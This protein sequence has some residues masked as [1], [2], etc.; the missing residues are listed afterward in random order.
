MS[1]QSVHKAVIMARGLGTRLRAQAAAELSAEQQAV[2]ATGVK[3]MMPVGGGRP[4]V[5]HVIHELAEAGIDEVCLVIGPEHE[6]V[7]ERYANLPTR[8]VRISL[9]TQAEPLGTADAVA[10]ARDF[11]GGDRFVVVNSDN[12]YPAAALRALLAAP[13][14]ATLGFDAAALV[15]RSNIPAERVAAFALLEVDAAGHLVDLAEKPGPEE[16]ARHGEHALVSM[17]CFCFGPSI[18]DACAAIE[19]SPRGELEIV[20]AV[21]HLVA[22]GEPVTVVPV[23]EG[24]LDLSGR[25]DVARVAAELADVDVKL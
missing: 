23:A 25:G 1:E 11:A 22:A 21:R 15:Q 3:A 13:G 18:F 19:P 4:F 7:R 9:A 16:L 5:E 20:D 6:Q 8:R 2:A 24:V 14:T 17:N 12:H 10:A